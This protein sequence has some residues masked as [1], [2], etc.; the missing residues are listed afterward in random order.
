[1]HV[2]GPVHWSLESKRLAS[3]GW[4]TR[5]YIQFVSIKPGDFIL[6]DDDGALVIPAPLAEQVLAEAERL[7][8]TVIQSWLGAWERSN[9]SGLLASTD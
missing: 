9:I 1:M 4:F 8:A 3:S 6:G 7:I 5:R 2:P